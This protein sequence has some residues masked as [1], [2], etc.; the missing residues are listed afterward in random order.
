MYVL[1]VGCY[2]LLLVGE[3]G[4]GVGVT[5]SRT[6]YVVALEDD[7]LVLDV[8]H[9]N[10]INEHLLGLTA[11][12]QSALEAQ[13]RVGATETA[14]AYHDAT[15]AL[16]GLATQYKA[17]VGVEDGV[18]LNQDIFATVGRSLWLVLAALHG[19]HR[20]GRSTSNA[21]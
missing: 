8:V 18:V 10:A 21:P 6:V 3:R 13:T 2:F 1:E 17:S 11:T 19:H 9:D 16:H 7:G 4:Y 20:S 5:A 14:I 15:H 12:T